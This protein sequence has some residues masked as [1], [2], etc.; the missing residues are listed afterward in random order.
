[1]RRLTLFTLLALTACTPAQTEAWLDWWQL[2]PRAAV[3]WAVNECGA[4]CTDD[5]DRDGI[6]EPE[7][8][9]EASSVVRGRGV[10]GRH[11]RLERR[12]LER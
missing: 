1:M 2:E 8:S 4:L 12:H 9:A 6:V 10:L 11:R 3:R 7:P 5:W